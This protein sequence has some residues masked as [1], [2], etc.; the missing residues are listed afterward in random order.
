MTQIGM[1]KTN[2]I[3]FKPMDNVWVIQVFD[4]WICLGF[5]YSN[6]EFVTTEYD[7]GDPFRV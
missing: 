7:P 6:L 1:I 3:T 2:R 5:R 4:I